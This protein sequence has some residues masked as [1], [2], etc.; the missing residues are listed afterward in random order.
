[1]NNPLN[2]IVMIE[3]KL[4]DLWIGAYWKKD[5]SYGMWHSWICLVPC[6]PLHITWNIR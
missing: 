1:M 3:F 2:L 5:I 6:I 4:E